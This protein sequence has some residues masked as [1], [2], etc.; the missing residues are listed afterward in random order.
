MTAQ[1]EEKPQVSVLGSD[2]TEIETTP[3][4]RLMNAYVS[5]PVVLD[6]KAIGFLIDGNRIQGT[7]TPD[8]TAVQ[9][10]GG[11]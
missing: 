1:D 9:Q 10:L 11:C 6:P 3:M 8:D 4:E 7:Q 2:G 5:R